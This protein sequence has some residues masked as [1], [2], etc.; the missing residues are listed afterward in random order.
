M[1]LTQLST[2]SALSDSVTIEQLDDVKIVRVRHSKA[3]A[4]ISLHGGHDSAEGRTLGARV[5]PTGANSPHPPLHTRC[6]SLRS[7]EQGCPFW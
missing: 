7:A 5:V 2:I 6:S 4:A 3:E 1:D